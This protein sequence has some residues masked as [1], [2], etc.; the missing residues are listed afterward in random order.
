MKYEISKVSAFSLF[1]VGFIFYFII[2]LL[3]A[4]V[5]GF[6]FGIILSSPVLTGFDEEIFPGFGDEFLRFMTSGV[7]IAFLIIGMI[8]FSFFYGFIG[9]FIFLIAGLL[10]NIISGALGGV[11]VELNEIQ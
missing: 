11:K 10:Y 7:P 9:G 2:G 6:V 5:W 4:L 3:I 8:F 1:K